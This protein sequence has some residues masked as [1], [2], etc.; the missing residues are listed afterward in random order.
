[1]RYLFAASKT[2]P[3]YGGAASGTSM[4][5][6]SLSPLFLSILA[7][8]FFTNEENGLDVS[9]YTLFL[10]VLAGSV[11]FVSGFFLPAPASPLVVTCES[12]GN[13]S[14][15]SFSD[16]EAFDS[17]VDERAPLV[18]P[19]PAADVRVSVHPVDASHS[20]LDLMKDPYFWIIFV[21]VMLLIGTVSISFFSLVRIAKR[22]ISHTSAKWS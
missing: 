7:T 11:Y 5:L 22:S 15:A 16:E 13:G 21:V 4:A 9:R 2:F 14:N 12:E 10:A 3:Q 19:K 20:S 1:M 17:E 6:Y 8:R 18:S